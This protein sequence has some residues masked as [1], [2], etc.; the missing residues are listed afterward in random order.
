MD[1]P[2][3]PEIKDHNTIDMVKLNATLRPEY[4]QNPHAVRSPIMANHT[5]EVAA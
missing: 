5:I 2:R 4:T 3:I 1:E